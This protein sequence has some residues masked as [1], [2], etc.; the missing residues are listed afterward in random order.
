MKLQRGAHGEVL[1]AK[2]GL[3][4]GRFKRWAGILSLKHITGTEHEQSN[5][6][7]CRE[8]ARVGQL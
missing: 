3:D 8:A 6:H 1:F 7:V 5:N 2:D 4:A